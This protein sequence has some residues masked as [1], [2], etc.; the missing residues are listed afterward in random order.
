MKAWYRDW[1]RWQIDGEL[2]FE[3]FVMQTL[4]GCG[5]CEAAADGSAKHVP[6]MSHFQRLTHFL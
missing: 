1:E 5:P 6:V 3:Y 4:S 2:L